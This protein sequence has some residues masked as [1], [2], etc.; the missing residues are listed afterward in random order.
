MNPLSI[1]QD[2]HGRYIRKLRLSLLDK[3][4]FRCFYC[5]PLNA[6]FLPTSELL[7]P[8]EI[9]DIC[10][11]LVKLGITQIRVT[12]GEPTLR[13][14]FD[15][16]MARLAN[17]QAEKLSLTTNGFHLTS[18]L[19]F[20]KKLKCH[21]INI[22]M[23]SLSEEKFNKI[24]HSKGFRKVYESILEAKS[25]GFIVKINALLLKGVNDEELFDFIHFSAEHDIEVRFLELMKI[26]QG[27]LNQKTQFLSADEAIQR[28]SEREKLTRAQVEPDSTSFNF[29]T[30][31]GAKIGFIASE[32]KPFCQSCS[33]LRL[34][35]TGKL[36]ACLMSEKGVNLRGVPKEEYSEILKT[37]LAMKP[38]GRIHHL[39]QNMNQIGG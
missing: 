29:I 13:K 31:S 36:R 33:R 28:I 18:K 32:S 11:P 26:G 12:G 1:L 3:C 39:N 17:L 19:E 23:D 21:H 22:S 20:L 9:E 10:D 35:A 5:M 24:T 14:D 37:V 27:C 34:T 7:T 25:Q 30:S 38:T 16:I 4:N 2:P 8:Q 15:E 6:K